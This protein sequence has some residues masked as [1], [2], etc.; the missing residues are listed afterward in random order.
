KKGKDAAA[1]CRDQQA[2][3]NKQ[4]SQ[5]NNPSQT[6]VTRNRINSGATVP[7]DNT[8]RVSNR[9][10]E[11]PDYIKKGKKGNTPLPGNLTLRQ[12]R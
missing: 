3:R 7:A 1:R 2:K 12:G 9:P 6:S 5:R 4:A 11:T 8:R 10:P